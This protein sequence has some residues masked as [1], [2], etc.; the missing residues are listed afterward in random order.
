MYY[1]HITS[2]HPPIYFKSSLDYLFYIIFLVK[3]FILYWSIANAQFCESLRWITKGLS[4]KYTCIHFGYMYPY[5]YPIN[6][7]FTQAAT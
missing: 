5:M 3:L 2:A 4:H 7:S 1:L 6:S